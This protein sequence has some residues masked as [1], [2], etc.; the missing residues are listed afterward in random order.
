MPHPVTCG[1]CNAAFS[2]PD[3]VWEKRVEGQVATLKCRQCKAPILIDGRTRKSSSSFSTESKRK[4][5]AVPNEAHAQ[6]AL[7]PVPQIVQGSAAAPTDTKSELKAQGQASLPDG[8]SDATAFDKRQPTNAKATEPKRFGA[9]S[10]GSTLN[11]TPEIA[12]RPMGST[13]SEVSRPK[14]DAPVDARG[15]PAVALSATKS[16]KQA[17]SPESRDPTSPR[18]AE[19]SRAKSTSSAGAAVIAPRGASTTKTVGIQRKLDTKSSPSP[20]E[21]TRDRKADYS[22]VVSVDPDSDREMTMA[23][24]SAAIADGTIT[25]ENIV[26]REGMSEWAP[27]STVPELKHLA[28]HANVAGPSA[29]GRFGRGLPSDGSEDETFVYRPENK[30]ANIASAGATTTSKFAVSTSVPSSSGAATAKSTG[31]T[32]RDAGIVRDGADVAKVAKQT[33][34]SHRDPPATP[35]AARGAVGPVKGGGPP[36][37]RKAL[38]STPDERADAVTSEEERAGEAQ[39]LGALAGMGT[40]NVGTGPRST[41]G[42]PPPLPQQPGSPRTARAETRDLVL[43]DHSP[44]SLP[45][46]TALEPPRL[47]A[48]V[49]AA[50][51]PS[52]IA[53]LMRMRPKFPKWLPFAAL[54]GIVLLAAVFAGMSWFGNDNVGESGKSNT[55]SD[56]GGLPLSA[57]TNAGINNTN[58]TG[59]GPESVK[60]SE[61]RESSSGFANQFAQAAAKQRPTSH[62][63]RES[64]EKA[65]TPG[66]A[67]AAACHNKGEPTGNVAVTLSISPSGQILSVTVPPPFAGTFTAE[68]IRNALTELRV[69]PF[70]GAP[71]RL[72]HSISIR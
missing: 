45:V 37:L 64:A 55:S 4:E 48:A 41:A 14:H 71:A 69:P 28:K 16:P 12:R 30:A 39:S 65:L 66:F 61:N 15:T 62:F 59:S 33:G 13:E 2:I 32:K 58:T 67:K 38:A 53:A 47:P 68:C 11:A 19:P 6:P 72:A 52:D 54:G 60:T 5:D 34:E 57:S 56:K 17:L 63:E 27:I 8:T 31:S 50:S 44:A 25:H 21:K 20:D 36:P 51:S 9:Q 10:S 46:V 29:G 42:G 18:T 22:W 1:A 26:W 49:S 43:H 24:I 40:R 70:Q 23:Q 7:S 3:D 35:A